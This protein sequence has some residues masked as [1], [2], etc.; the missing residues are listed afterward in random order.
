MIHGSVIEP[1]LRTLAG[2]ECVRNLY[3]FAVKPDED[4]SHI[5]ANSTTREQDDGSSLDGSQLTLKVWQ[6]L[7]ARNGGEP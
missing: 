7:G 4:V 6:Q 1:C 2:E 3:P 5:K